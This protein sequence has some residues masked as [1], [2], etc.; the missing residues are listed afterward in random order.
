[1]RKYEWLLAGLL[2]LA[3][4]VPTFAQNEY[5]TYRNARFDYSIAYPSALLIPQGEAENGDGQKFLS[6]DGRAEVMV[7]GSHNALDQSFRDAYEEAAGTS[8]HPNRSVT[9]KVLRGDWF[10]VS[11]TKGKKTFY[12]KTI[13]RDGVFKTFRIEY[14]TDQKLIFNP[15]TTKIAASFKG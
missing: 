11:G 3:I 8:Q 7:F 5:Q 4:L 9:Y 1:M 10:V 2:L 15:V 14:D 12:Q 13:L 6:R